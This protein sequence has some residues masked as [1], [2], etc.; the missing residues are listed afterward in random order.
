MSTMNEIKNTPQKKGLAT[1]RNKK[2]NTAI[3]HNSKNI[4]KTALLSKSHY[5]EYTYDNHEKIKRIKTGISKAELTTLKEK[6]GLDYDQLANILSVSRMTL[7][8]KKG[9]DT[10]DITTSEK[11]F[12]LAELYSYGYHVFNNQEK[13]KNWMLTSNPAL[14]DISP[15]SCMDTVY[16]I[17]E[18]KNL[19]GRID[20]GIIS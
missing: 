14:G 16:G 2:S 3:H 15:I 8:K 4:N 19:I 13:F 17:M 6:I 10:F 5:A 12:M 18:V 1:I 7:F 9:E 11:L 20:Y